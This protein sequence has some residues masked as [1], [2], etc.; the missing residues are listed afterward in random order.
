M[1]D[2]HAG[3]AQG[4]EEFSEF[5]GGVHQARTEVL[6]FPLRETEDN[7]EICADSGA[8]RLDDFHGKTAAF[9]QA[10]AVGIL[11]LIRSFPEKLVDQV[12]VGT[13]QLDR[14][15]PTGFGVSRRAGK[16]GHHVVDILLS[17]HMTVHLSGHIHTRRCMTRHI[18][19]GHNAGT[20]HAAHVPELRCNL[21]A[22]GVYR[23]RDTTPAGEALLTV[24]IRHVRVAVRRNVADA[25]ALGDNQA[26]TAF[27]P[28]PVVLDHGVARHIAG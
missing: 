11:A 6:L 15:K 9:G 26:G 23:I 4:R 27:R 18:P 28:A 3:R 21:A 16:R 12:A 17:H 2:I 25:G 8:H 5:G 20:A 7:G 1:K 24:E 14:V 10:A 19:F 22:L 13:V